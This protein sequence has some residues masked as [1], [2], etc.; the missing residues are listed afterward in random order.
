MLAKTSS[1]NERVPLRHRKDPERQVQRPCPRSFRPRS[2][3][4]ARL[5]PRASSFE[6][7]DEEARGVSSRPP[8]ERR[9]PPLLSVEH[10]DDPAIAG[11]LLQ[12]SVSLD[13]RKEY[14]GLRKSKSPANAPS[15]QRS[16]PASPHPGRLDRPR[17]P[18]I[19]RASRRLSP[20]SAAIRS[21]ARAAVGARHAVPGKRPGAPTPPARLQW[22]RHCRSC[23]F[24]RSLAPSPPR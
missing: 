24:V 10:S 2:V 18:S 5:F 20:T 14:R 8:E 11:D 12:E 9:A 7:R 6:R 15:Q 17:A 23:A 16:S 21:P 22:H 4:A 19:R 3:V 1:C 13:R